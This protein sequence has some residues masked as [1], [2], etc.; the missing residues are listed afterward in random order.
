MMSSFEVAITISTLDGQRRVETRALVDTASTLVVI[1]PSLA[2]RLE[3]IPLAQERFRLGNEEPIDLPVTNALITV[4]GRTT[5]ARVA[6]GP[7][8]GTPIL[9]VT[10]LELLALAVDPLRER[11]IPVE[12]LLKSG[13]L[14]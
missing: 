6:I 2:R 11:L 8:E 9:G 14:T 1:P 10:V 4:E 7:A 5:A 12:Y 13:I 3:L